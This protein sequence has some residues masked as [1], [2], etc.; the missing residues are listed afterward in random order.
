M[1]KHFN[2]T[3]DCLIKVSLNKLFLFYTN[4]EFLMKLLLSIRIKIHVSAN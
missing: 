3:N 2:K 1:D 4:L